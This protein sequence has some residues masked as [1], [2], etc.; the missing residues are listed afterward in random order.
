MLATRCTAQLLSGPPAGSCGEVAHRLLAIQSQD[1]RG[2]RLSIRA[3][4]VGVRASDVDAALT[5]GALLITWLNRGTLHLVRAEDYWWLHPLTTPQLATASA[6]RLA[7]E[8][9]S[10][11]QAA[12]GV[13]VLAEQVGTMGPRTRSELRAALD[14]AG[15]PTAGQ[16]LVHI[17]LAASL[18]GRLVR[19]PMRGGEHCYA[20]TADWLGAAP[21][22]LER[23]EALTR[24]ARRYLAGHGPADARDLAKWAGI[25]LGE[26]HR[27]LAGMADEVARRSDGLVDLACREPPAPL[28]GPRLLG[29]FDPLLHGW[30]SRAAVVG[31]HKGIV[32]SNGLFRPFALVGGRAVA[33]WAIAGGRVTIRLLQPIPHRALQSL[34]EDAAD[35]LRYLDLP[36]R[37]AVVER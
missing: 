32:T 31:P 21:E 28:P 5:D 25:P 33:T 6:R 12:H 1:P 34:E 19:G 15:V 18:Q 37:P 27:G 14:E 22:P 4:S 20:A 36:A 2:A 13:E 30:V 9:V 16:A 29:S 8:G 11:A 23:P 10:A 24:L 17:L 3:R 35:V 7:Q 26:A